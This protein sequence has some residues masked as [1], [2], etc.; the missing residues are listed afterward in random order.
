MP[1][2]EALE[3]SSKWKHGPISKEKLEKFPLPRGCFDIWVLTGMKRHMKKLEKYFKA[4]WGKYQ[5]ER[6]RKITEMIKKG[7]YYEWWI[8]KKENPSFIDSTVKKEN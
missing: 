3:R 1:D 7:Q 5:E 2:P 8:H 4:R 6:L